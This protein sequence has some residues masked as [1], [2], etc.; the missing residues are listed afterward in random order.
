M[1]LCIAILT[2]I[3]QATIDGRLQNIDFTGWGV[4]IRPCEHLLL[5]QVVKRPERRLQSGMELL[6][7][8]SFGSTTRDFATTLLRAGLLGYFPERP[9]QSTSRRRYT[10]RA[11]ATLNDAR[12]RNTTALSGKHGNVLTCL[13]P[14]S[15]R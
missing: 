7:K 15:Q 1:V 9:G 13:D 12:Q 5:E 3:A 14:F 6:T 2:T 4:I 11:R 8:V 10:R